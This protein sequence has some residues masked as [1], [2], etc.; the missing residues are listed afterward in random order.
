[1][2][3]KLSKMVVLLSA[4]FLITTGGAVYAQAST[5]NVN[6]TAETTYTVQEMLTYAI[7]DEYAAQ[8][9]YQGI[10]EKY[11]NVKPFSNVVTAE[12]RHIDLVK[13][14]MEKYEVAVP[15]NDAASKVAAPESLLEAYKAGVAAEVRNIEMYNKFLGQNLPEDVKT[16]FT[17]LVRASENH[18]RA[19]EK[20]VSNPEGF[21]TGIGTGNGKNNGKGY[22]M[23]NGVG[24]CNSTGT[25]LNR[26]SGMG[27]GCG[28]GKG[29]KGFGRNR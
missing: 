2:K 7:L 8:A 14:L 17:S 26:Y 9:E 22:S 3:K 15:Q 24:S 28:Q 5:S 27:N 11:S 1:M 21:C 4:V 12:G 6:I 10:I 19:F 25:G 23:G 20:A 13:T 18:K 29:G 16:L